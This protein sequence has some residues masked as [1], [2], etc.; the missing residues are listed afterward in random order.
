MFKFDDFL[1]RAKSR[2]LVE[3]PVDWKYSDDD[4]NETA[5][6]IPVGVVPKPAAVLI[7]I[8][9]RGEPMVILTKRQDHLANHL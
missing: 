7:G 8:V 4:L 3:P 1:V 6:M 9:E 5:R 2:L